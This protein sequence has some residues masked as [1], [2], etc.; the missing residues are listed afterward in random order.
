MWVITKPGAEEEGD[1]LEVLR[2]SDR[3][4][5]ISLALFPGGLS[6]A[7]ATPSGGRGGAF[8]VGFWRGLA[9]A[10]PAFF[11]ARCSEGV[12]ELYQDLEAGTWHLRRA[13][14]L[15]ASAGVSLLGPAPQRLRF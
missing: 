2:R 12:F 9:G 15:P 8:L 1:G 6:L 3:R 11:R 13:C 4:H 10:R 14:P 5:P 7:E